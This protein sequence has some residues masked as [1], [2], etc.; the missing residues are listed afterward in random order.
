MEHFVFERRIYY[1]HTDAGGVVYYATYLHILE[2]GRV[3]FLR[4]NGVDVNECLKLDVAFPVVHVEVDYK[5][6][7]KYGD[8]VM[9]FTKIEKVG[10]ASIAFAQEIKRGDTLL[11]KAKTV[12]ACTGSDFKVKSIPDSVRKRLQEIHEKTA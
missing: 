3:E 12:W 6:P 2:E 7:A 9:V 5:A 8:V 4:A 11:I 1:H 10:Q